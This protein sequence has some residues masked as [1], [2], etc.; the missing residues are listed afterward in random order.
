LNFVLSGDQ[1]NIWSLNKTT[2]VLSLDLHITFN[3]GPAIFATAIVLSGIET[4]K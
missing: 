4:S 3:P 2:S 1:E